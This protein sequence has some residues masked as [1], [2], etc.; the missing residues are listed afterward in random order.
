M[1]SNLTRTAG[2]GLFEQI[3]P[4][5]TKKLYSSICRYLYRLSDSAAITPSAHLET[6]PKIVTSMSHFGESLTKQIPD[7]ENVLLSAPDQ[8]VKSSRK[9]EV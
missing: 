1:G 9:T 6:I 5:E 2:K 4:G 3:S 7:Y 8:D